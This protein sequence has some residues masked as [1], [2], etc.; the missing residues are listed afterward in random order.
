M[1]DEEAWFGKA[2]R[3][4][5]IA[6]TLGP[7][8]QTQLLNTL[9]LN[10]K[11]AEN[12][13]SALRDTARQWIDDGDSVELR[14]T[15]LL[16]AD[17]VDQ[18]WRI[19]LR[20]N[21][22]TFEPPGLS[23]ATGERAEDVKARVQRSLR[24]GRDRQL[25]EP[26][27]RA[28]I[29]RMERQVPR[30]DNG[31]SSVLDLVD[32][33]RDLAR[34]LAEVRNL[35]AGEQEAALRAV[36]DPVVEVCEP[37]VRCRDTGLLL[38]DI[39]RYFRHTWSHEYRSIPGRQMMVL[40][41]N[42]AR[43]NR[44]V[45][46]IAMLA[47]PV[48]RLSTRDTW[49]GWLR[50]AAQ[51]L[52]DSGEWSAHR[53]IQSLKVR[54]DASIQDLRWDDLVDPQAI[55]APGESLV[56]RLQQLAAGAAYRRGQQLRASYAD[57]RDG[58]DPDPSIARVQPWVAD[59]DWRRASE[60]LLFV[61]KRA[62]SLA[63]LIWAKMALERVEADTAEETAFRLFATPVGQRAV[64]IALAETRKAGL[65]S[66]VAD[67]SVCGAVHPYNEL[68]GG[69]LVA[70]LLAS[71]EVRDAYTKRYGGA[72]S[73][74]ASQMA[75]RAIIKPADLKVLTTTS[76]Y[77]L[78]SSQYNRLRLRADQHWGIPS[79]LEWSA[80]GRSLTGGYGTLHL[81]SDTLHALRELGE[82]RHDARRINNRFGE[83]T[84]PRLRQI[85]EG[86]DALGVESDKVLQ[87][88]TPRIFYGCELEPGARAVLRSSGARA[89][90]RAPSVAGIARAWRNR[91][92]LKRID[93]PDV[94]ILDRM[95]ALG[96][97]SI[98]AQFHADEEGQFPL[99]FDG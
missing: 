98:K 45:I 9:K 11:V 69:K 99:P 50:P 24:V 61:H 41:R 42:A 76:L 39:W 91:W 43:R 95:A 57:N 26:S 13:S 46:G 28:F 48:M 4:R 18:G 49:I 12:F 79:D 59:G 87:H 77:G 84:S 78:G 80:I 97:I 25:Q 44:P 68:L 37:S 36:V 2:G 72:V 20:D 54:L 58:D 71:R 33:G 81:G 56:H 21:R 90:R 47:S 22:I 52:V 85:R 83:G 65:S 96:P 63:D 1:S 70:L 86:L 38:N 66:R 64:D 51:A 35:P 17:L 88:A 8:Q 75:G 34:R 30:I 5:A 82:R 32:D 7:V 73:V 16:V 3:Q 55:A 23:A 27:V 62:K 92:A 93:N 10:L 60:D 40:V 6:P 15:S 67:V 74:I 19:N 89:P 14:A 31:K 29:R 94:D 53:F